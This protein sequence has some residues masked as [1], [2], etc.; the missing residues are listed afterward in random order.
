MRATPDG[1]PRHLGRV[2]VAAGSLVDRGA[3]PPGG[4]CGMSE[5]ALVHP[6]LNP[7]AIRT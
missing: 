5:P 3:S 1:V 4:G 6:R 2:A 7:P